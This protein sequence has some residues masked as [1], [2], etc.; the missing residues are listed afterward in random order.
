MF[1]GALTQKDI[2]IR[3]IEWEKREVKK[4]ILQYANENSPNLDTFITATLQAFADVDKHFED[5]SKS[6]S[7]V[8]L[9]VSDE[10]QV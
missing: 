9:S 7:T 1:S 4:A 10:K 6:T 2:K 8:N 3:S 5:K